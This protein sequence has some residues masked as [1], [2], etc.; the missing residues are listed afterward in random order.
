LVT[1]GIALLTIS[2]LGRIAAQA[3]IEILWFNSVG[4]SSVF[5]TRFFWEWGVQLIGG[6]LVGVAFFFNLRV[7]ARALGGIRIKRRV[8]DLEISEQIPENYVVWGIGVFS[9]LGGA[10]FAASIPG[11][12][13]LDVLFLLNAPEWGVTDPILGRDL[14]FFVL[15][16]PLL[17]AAA[18]AGLVVSFLIFTLAAAGYAGTGALQWGQG[19]LVIEDRPRKHLG[20]IAAVFFAVLAGQFYVFRYVLLLNGSSGVQGIFGFTDAG[21]R[22]DAYNVLAVLALAVSA[23][24]LWTGFKNRLV[25]LMA[26]F[27]LLIVGGLA[28][29]QVYP[30]FVQRF[31]V[32]PN[33]LERE[34]QYILENMRFTKMG[35]DLTD[36]ERR[37]FDYERTPNVDWLAAAAQFEGLPIWSSQALLT[38]YRQLE[39]R[40][41]YYEFSGVT[42]DRYE[43]LDG[44]VP[45]T[46]AVRE[47]LPRGIQDQNWQ[48]LHLRGEYI[49]GMGA[50]VSA[51]T[52][53][54][55]EGRPSMFVSGI[56]PEFSA[57]DDAPLGVNL[58]RPEV[59]I[60][61]RP[62][63]YAIVNPAATGDAA[64]VDGGEQQPGVDFPAGIQLDSPLRRLALAWRFRDW[65]LLI[66]GEV[67]RTS[68]FVFRRDV[69]DRVTRISGQLLR[70]PEAPY[71]VIHEGRIVWILEGFTWTSSFPLSTLQDLEAGRAVRYVR[72][73]VKI[74]IDGV[75]GEMNFYIVDDVDPLLQAYAEGLPGL[76]R[77]LSDM[78][79]GLRDHIRYPRSMLSLQARVLYQYHQ[80]TS[81]L[82]HG[83]QDVWTLPQELAQGTTPVP[84]QPEYGLYRLPGEEESDFLLTSVFVPRGR[85]NLT[86]ILT[87]SSDP[88]RYGEL[89]LFDVPV[90]DQVPGPRQVEAL[91]EQDPV[92]S[93]QFSL[94]RTGGS[95]VWTGHL[96]LVPVGRT[97]LYMEPVFLAAEEDAIPDLT[98]FVVSDGYRVAM[99]E[100]LQES[101]Q[102]LARIA[103]ASAPDLIFVDGPLDLPSLDTEQWPAEALAL[104]EAADAALR[105]GDFQGFG[106]AL[107]ELRGLLEGLSTGPTN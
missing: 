7:I 19:R 9:V 76:F 65:N 106:D 12:M 26:T 97:L 86:A 104:L 23:A 88:D 40:Y 16:L 17:R 68:R 21:A 45:V 41:P 34:S 89:V 62:Q 38:T 98:R 32:E 95:Q 31:R 74:T 69:L 33:E 52:A 75:T 85:Q 37:E 59:Y 77:P 55:P 60:G 63:Q 71:P 57:S 4:Y 6:V 35:F 53:R 70:F 91:I 44:L 84:Y 13:G 92:I 103:D 56:P 100:T 30:S 20:V 47:V 46:L 58:T 50:V 67:N 61:I 102:A 107:D 79:G 64:G 72:N 66:A 10:W 101:I 28:V 73:S 82:F 80:E 8:G 3:Y 14:T 96:H 93:Q 51:A 99:E 27:G 1:I 105:T 25:P 36:L 29:G 78:P 11:S 42:V 94:W 2:L 43:G 87:A 90:E 18:V 54:T 49:R 15:L 22:M 39:A 5:W 48:N 83:Q 81:R 24:A